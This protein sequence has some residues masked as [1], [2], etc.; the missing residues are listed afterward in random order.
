MVIYKLRNAKNA[1]NINMHRQ[2]KYK[3]T[4]QLTVV[5]IAE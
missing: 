1:K 4:V 5:H 3:C 2:Y